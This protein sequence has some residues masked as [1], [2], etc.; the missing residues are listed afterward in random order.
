MKKISLTIILS[1]FLTQLLLSQIELVPVSHKVYPFLNVLHKKGII[2]NYNN[3]NIPFDR[4]Q[5]TGYLSGINKN[6]SELTN[7]EKS[8]LNELLIE[9]SYD[10]E[11]SMDKSVSL[12]TNFTLGNLITDTKQK[13]LYSFADSNASFFLDGTAFISHRRFESESFNKTH[14]TIGE[15][16]F[17]VRGSLYNHVGYY[18]RVS[19]GQQLNGDRYSRTAASDYDP[20]LHSTL[21]FISEKYFETY[22]GY[23]RFASNNNALSFTLGREAVNM[24][25]GY[26][27]KLFVGS[28]SAPFDFGKIDLGYK[29]IKYSFLYG[30]LRGDSLGVTLESKNI[31]NH[32]LD[33]SFS[34]SFKLGVYEAVITAN[35]PISF[36]YMNPL[37]FLFSAD[38]NAAKGNESN[39]MIGLDLEILPLKNIGF[40]SSFLIDDF[41]FKLIGK[42]TPESNNNRFG[43][44]F[45][46]FYAGTFGIENLS[47]AVEY[48]HL[49]PFTYSHKSNK[50]QYAHWS[51]PLGH[52]LKPNS[53]E[54]AVKFDYLISGRLK[55][56]LKFQYQR[57]GQGFDYDNTGK[58]VRNYGA[59]INH[60]EGLYLAK[61][62][63]LDGNRVNNSI[64]TVNIIFEP[65][66]QYFIDLTYVGWMIDKKYKSEKFTDHF[67]YLTVSTDL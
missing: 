11:R 29:G 13:Y 18:L 54:I 35:T 45:G 39:S 42:D 48:T 38:L 5:V 1:L 31:I 16:G 28:N 21:K 3:A 46:L 24:G 56:S 8:L 57:T 14:L 67:F 33:I 41:D 61:A 40:Q 44:Q 23:L 47:S 10:M 22:E 49:D 53:D 4:K 43:W 6:I 64:L 50:S 59:D 9:F 58:L 19:S 15:Y 17:R 63:F 55:T 2:E 66:K 26:I 7:S 30:N 51:L 32:R 34:N 36:T 37:S 20:K 25:T 12:F 62:H 52:A 60:G 27:D 65:I